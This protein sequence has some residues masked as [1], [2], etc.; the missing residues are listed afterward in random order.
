MFV[1]K[2]VFSPPSETVSSVHTSDGL[3]K[4]P[5]I[6]PLREW[7]GRTEERERTKHRLDLLILM[8][9]RSVEM[10]SLKRK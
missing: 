3:E 6:I 5:V 4:C 10:L 9:I 2:I 1:F 8:Q 7:V